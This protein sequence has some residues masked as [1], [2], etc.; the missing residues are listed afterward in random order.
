MQRGSIERRGNCWLLKY[1]EPV[2]IDGQVVKRQKAKKL[3]TFSE[4]YYTK[5]SVQHLADEILAPINARSQP[6]SG[7]TVAAF[8]EHVY[9]QHVKETKKPTT[10]KSYQQMFA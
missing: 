9:L 4:Q 5:E 8:L 1:Y 2:M 6:E 7:Q 10:V 3:A